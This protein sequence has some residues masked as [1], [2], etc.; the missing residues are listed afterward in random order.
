MRKVPV[1]RENKMIKVGDD[2]GRKVVAKL[3]VHELEGIAFELGK[4]VDELGKI[5]VETI[6]AGAK[7][8]AERVVSRA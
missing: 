7:T 8:G 3:R 5:V 1:E 6:K 4:V 2:P